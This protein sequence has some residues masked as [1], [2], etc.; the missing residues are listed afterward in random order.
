MGKTSV[1]IELWKLGCK[2]AIKVK[3]T[4]E[5][6]PKAGAKHVTGSIMISRLHALKLPHDPACQPT[7]YGHAKHQVIWLLRGGLCVCVAFEPVTGLDGMIA[8]CG[9]SEYL[10]NLIPGLDVPPVFVSTQRRDV[11]DEDV[12]LADGCRDRAAAR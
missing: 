3:M 8:A 5:L 10:S 11:E 4:E 1:C 7:L 12:P 6:W 2:I 9:M